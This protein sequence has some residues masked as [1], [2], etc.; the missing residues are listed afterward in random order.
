MVEAW[1]EVYNMAYS[2]FD[3]AAYEASGP[4]PAGVTY[5]TLTLENDYLRLTFLPEVGGRL[6]EVFYK[7]TGHRLTYRN[8]VLKPSVPCRI[9][10]A[11]GPAV[12]LYPDRVTDR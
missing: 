8:P 11:P 2:V 9:R 5:Q 3:R 1:S 6:Y 4:L 10:P 12:F 7:P